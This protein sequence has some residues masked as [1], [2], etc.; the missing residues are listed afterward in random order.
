VKRRDY[1][2]YFNI[3]PEYRPFFTVIIT[4]YNRASLV[5]RALDSLISQTEKDW[6]AVISDDGSTDSTYCTILPYLESNSEIA[7]IRHPHRGISYAKNA[8]LRASRGKYITFLD[9]DDE[10]HPFHLESRKS[11][12]LQN[13][14]VSF[15]HGGIKIIGDPFVPDRFDQTKKV[16]LKE[17][18][19]GG[20]FVIERETAL[21]LKGFRRISFGE[22]AE[23]FDRASKKNFKILQVTEPTYIYHH[24]TGDSITN[25]IIAGQ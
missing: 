10:F 9:S 13:P 1:I 4:T 2:S 8:G 25:R 12:L 21:A 3:E 22:D 18:I 17:C 5:T 19:I 7:Y 11:I 14:L 15:L 16:N 20:T 24:E 23:L 6:E